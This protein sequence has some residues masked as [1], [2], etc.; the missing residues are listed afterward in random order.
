MERKLATLRDIA[1]HFRMETDTVTPML[2]MWI[3]K[4]KLKKHDSNLGCR[5]GC[6]KCDPSTIET[7]EWTA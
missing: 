4:G 6:C 2:D 1:T 5:K 3:R 7:Y